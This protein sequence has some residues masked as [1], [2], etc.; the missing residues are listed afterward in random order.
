MIPVLGLPVLNGPDHLDKLL[1]SID[2]P[3]GKVVIIDN[4]DVVGDIGHTVIK[5]RVN[6]GVAESWNLIIRSFPEA[7]YW[8]ISNHDIVYAPGELERLADAV[9]EKGGLV[10]LG[11][12]SVFALTKA[13]VKE[14][15]WFDCNF[16]PAYFEDNDFDYRCRLAGVDISAI[17]SGSVHKTSS[18]LK[19]EPLYRTQNGKTFRLNHDYYIAK[20]GGEPYQEQFKT[21]F[22]D[23]GDPRECALDIDRLAEQWW[24]RVADKT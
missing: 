14:V 8:V 10:M 16:H 18:T 9:D 24:H 17:P 2:T 11:G 13:V 20:W 23:G 1:A 21:P 7:P 4:G 12:M 5:P 22:D 3:V 6:I 15:G 19:D